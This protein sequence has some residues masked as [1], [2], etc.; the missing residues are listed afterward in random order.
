MAAISNTTSLTLLIEEINATLQQTEALLEAYTLELR[1]KQQQQLIELL[2]QVRGVCAMVELPA[3]TMMSSEM[4]Q[5]S[6]ALGT[7]KYP[8]RAANALS[9]AKIGRASC[10][11]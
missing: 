5:L 6:E 4:V 2:Q 10:R 1:K 9:R 3:A 7:V 8:E 11:E